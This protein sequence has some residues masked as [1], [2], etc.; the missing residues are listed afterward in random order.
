MQWLL[1]FLW[2]GR[3][4]QETCLP[5][6]LCIARFIFNLFAEVFHWIPESY[7]QW[8]VDHY[9]DDFIATLPAH[10]A[11]PAKLSE[12]ER[13]YKIVTDQLSIPRQQ[14]KDQ[15]GTV[16]PPFGIQVDSYLFIAGWPHE[17][18]AKAVAATAAALTTKSLTSPVSHRLSFFL[19]QS[20]KTGMGIH[21]TPVNFCCQLPSQ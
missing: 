9:L 20:G 6:G 16:I 14:S 5:F 11:T 13:Q 2:K 8:S 21:A 10:K 15:T 17:K 4:Y 18:I 12:Y 19:C 7:L 1:G 3:H